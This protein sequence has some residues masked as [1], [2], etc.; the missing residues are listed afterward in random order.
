MDVNTL[1]T[2]NPDLLVPLLITTILFFLGSFGFQI[3]VSRQLKNAGKKWNTHIGKYT[4]LRPY[5]L[6]WQHAK[7]LQIVDIMAFWSFLLFMT[8]AG[9]FLTA[10]TFMQTLP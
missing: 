6:G 2:L 4:W 10:L 7:E 3:Y 8:G 1:P 5:L 9:F